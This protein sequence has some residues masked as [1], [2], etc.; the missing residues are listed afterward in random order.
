[1]SRPSSPGVVEVWLATPEAANHFDP[2]RLS[3]T[4]RAEWAAIRTTRRRRD[5][6]SSRALLGAVPTAGSMHSSLSHSHGYAALAQVSGAIGVGV[7]IEWLAP[8]NF[9]GLAGIAFSADEARYLASLDDPS[10]LCAVFYEFWTLKEAFAKALHLTLTDALRQCRFVD[11]SGAP[12]ATVPTT[13]RWRATVFAPQPRL[14]L[15]VVS[16]ATDVEALPA[17]PRT[18]EWPPARNAEWLVVRDLAGAG[19]PAAGAC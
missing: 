5:W 4:D 10:R 15:A 16:V 14:R 8:R 3:G 19:S 2:S 18:Q 1:M 17:T 6:A 13:R 9:N 7:D 11:A 12:A